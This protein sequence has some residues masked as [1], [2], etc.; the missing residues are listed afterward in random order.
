MSADAWSAWANWLL[1]GLG[2]LGASFVEF[3]RRNR[4]AHLS[5]L[6]HVNAETKSL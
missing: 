4:A 3:A 2:L 5:I 6:A 1:G